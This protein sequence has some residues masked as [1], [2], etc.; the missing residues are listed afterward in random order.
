[1]DFL[2]KPTEIEKGIYLGGIAPTTDKNF[3][4]NMNVIIDMIDYKT[5]NLPYY[6]N[7]I[8]YNFP[9][10]DIST[11]NISQYFDSI[12]RII[13]KYRGKGANVYIHCMAGI[14]RSVTVLIAYFMKRD[15][16]SAGEAFEKIQRKRPIVL[17]NEGFVNQLMKYQKIIFDEC[18]R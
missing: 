3:M 15:C 13:H 10:D 16:I 5:E 8:Y 2:Q 14:S 4:K 17:P 1:M 7:V 18:R 6:P 11:E 9:V 12:Y